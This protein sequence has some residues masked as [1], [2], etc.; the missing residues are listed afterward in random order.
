MKYSFKNDYSEGC[1]PKILEALSQNNFS[2][3]NG[4]GEDEFCLKAEKIIIE[5]C[6]SPQSKIH[7]VGGGTF[8]NLLV[9]SALLKSYESVISADSGHINSNETGAIE[10]CGHKI[11]NIASE[12]GKLSPEI[13]I[14]V[15]EN[16]TNFP[17]QVKPKMVYISNSTE[18]GTVYTKQELEDLSKFCK[19]KNLYFFMDGARLGHALTTENSDVN[20]ENIAKLTDVFYLGGTKNGAM[21]GEAIVVNN[22]EIL[23]DIRFHMKQK[24]GLLAKGRFLGIQFLTLFEND[25]Y[26]E[27]AK[28]ANNQAQKLKIAFVD[29]GFKLLT[30]THSNQIFPILNNKQIEILQNLFEFYIWKKIDE[31]FSAIRLVTSWSTENE[32][33]ESFVSEIKKL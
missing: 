14:P 9:I 22:P 10:Y 24:G 16:H 8:A 23:E 11:H 7:F 13:I 32:V 19:E 5:K 1:H 20:L 26:F 33:V 18:L 4:Y 21:F 27:L 30:E 12:N 29:K 25:L 6:K 2:Q 17:H 28:K 3:Q 15:L 31:N